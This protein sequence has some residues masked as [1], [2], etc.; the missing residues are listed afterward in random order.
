MI[1]Y[2]LM[3]FLPAILA[4]ILFRVFMKGFRLGAGLLG[5]LAGIAAIVP[6]AFLQFF[7]KPLSIFN[8]ETFFSLIATSFIFNGLIEE[9]LKF[10]CLFIVPR[11]IFK[12]SSP[13]SVAERAEEGVFP[14]FA[15]CFVAGLSIGGF[16]S[17][18]YLLNTFLQGT[19]VGFGAVV[20][21]VVTRMFT[22]VLIHAFCAG[23]SGLCIFRK[24]IVPLLFA[25]LLHGTY[26]YFA[27]F[28]N[29]FWLFSI[30]AILL[31]I[32]ECRIFIKNSTSDN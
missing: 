19:D 12:N 14:Y 11:K 3:S 2:F 24:N 17:I 18:I 27:R 29:A 10:G 22:A 4:L 9:L 26:D 23:L 28:S 7:V 8:A 16:E 15:C 32:L 30:V 1:L 13:T 6:I 5:M 25:I 21:F 20:S 31:S